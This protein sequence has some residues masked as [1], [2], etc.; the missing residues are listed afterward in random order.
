MNGNDGR[1]RQLKKRSIGAW[2]PVLGNL[3]NGVGTIL[4]R[5]IPRGVKKTVEPTNKTE[6]PRSPKQLPDNLSPPQETFLLP[7]PALKDST[8]S[9]FNT[10]TNSL[11]ND[12]SLDYMEAPGI[13]AGVVNLSPPAFEQTFIAIEEENPSSNFQVETFNVPTF[14]QSS[15]SSS[16]SSVPNFNQVSGI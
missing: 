13:D 8:F 16:F 3:R 2:K 9:T 15:S 6:K 4:Q 12:I 14:S 1:R 11:S 7:P 5:L 10:N